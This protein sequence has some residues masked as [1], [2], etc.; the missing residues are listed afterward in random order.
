[1][2]QWLPR[3]FREDQAESRESLDAHATCNM[4]ISFPVHDRVGRVDGVRAGLA[5]WFWE[6]GASHL[7]SKQEVYRMWDELL[8]AGKDVLCSGMGI[9][10]P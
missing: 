7:L 6:K 2:E 4:K 1:M 10:S 9:T 5:W 8:N 3:V